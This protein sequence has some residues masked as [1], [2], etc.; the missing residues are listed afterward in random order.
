MARVRRALPP[1]HDER[2]GENCR[3]GTEDLIRALSATN[4]DADA[5]RG[6][7]G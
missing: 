6:L 4:E 1:I 7:T 3:Q 5:G 2:R